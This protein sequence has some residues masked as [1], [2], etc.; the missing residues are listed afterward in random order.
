MPTT[1]GVTLIMICCPTV[2]APNLAMYSAVKSTVGVVF[3]GA[4]TINLNLFLAYVMP[5]DML[6]VASTSSACSKGLGFAKSKDTRGVEPSRT[7]LLMPGAVT[8]VGKGGSSMG[9]PPTISR[10]ILR[11]TYKFLPL[12]LYWSPKTLVLDH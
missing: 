10:F 3:C 7:R 6:G 1:I 2:T 4:D 5:G 8:S 12:G 9:A 11:L